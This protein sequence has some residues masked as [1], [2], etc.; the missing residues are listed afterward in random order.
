MLAAAHAGNL[1]GP[2]GSA[3]TNCSAQMLVWSRG[4]W[5]EGKMD[6]TEG[7]WGPFCWGQ[8]GIPPFLDMS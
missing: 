2:V 7:T 4:D 3:W 8:P 6:K 1:H 5:A